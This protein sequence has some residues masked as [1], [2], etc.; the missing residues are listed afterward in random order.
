MYIYTNLLDNTTGCGG[1]D[2]Y[3]DVTLTITLI[4]VKI[5]SS[6]NLISINTTIHGLHTS[7]KQPCQVIAAIL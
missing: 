3:N 5:I 4:L 6:R 2:D 7:A 1:N